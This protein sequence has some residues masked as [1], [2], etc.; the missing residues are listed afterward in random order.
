MKKTALIFAS[1]LAGTFCLTAQVNETPVHTG[2]Q[3]IA[4]KKQDSQA[5]TGSMYLEDQYLPAQVSSNGNQVVLL[6]Y[7]A[8][9]DY[10]EKNDPQKG[11][12][13]ELL[14]DK[15]ATIT[16]KGS[17]N[18]YVYTSYKND[19]D[20]SVNGYLEIVS[21]NPNVKIYKKESIYLKPESFPANSYQTYKPAS[22]NKSK[23]Q[24]FIQLN[25][26]DIVY[27]SHR[28][29]D[30]AKMVPGKEKEIKT[31]IKKNGIDLDEDKDLEQLGGYLQTIL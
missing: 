3:Q 25:G 17:G 1:L 24:Y 27:L 20:E 12:T 11:T 16:F 7:N 28:W 30:L 13:G 4:L 5:A 26:G 22:Y 9:S 29:K 10:F 2:G 21:D 6:R 15:N 19:D 14:K 18:T 23:D 31:Y 8:Y